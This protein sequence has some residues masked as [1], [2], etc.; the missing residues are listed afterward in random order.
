MQE[1]SLQTVLLVTSAA[2]MPR[3]L[4][5]FRSQGVDVIPSPTDIAVVGKKK[6]SIFDWLPDAGALA[7]TTMAIKEHIGYAIYKWRGWIKE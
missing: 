4:A 7:Q 1:Y 5:V 3:A 2:H 6:L